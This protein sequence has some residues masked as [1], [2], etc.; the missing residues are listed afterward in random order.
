MGDGSEEGAGLVHRSYRN[1]PVGVDPSI[2]LTPPPCPYTAD[3]ARAMIEAAIVSGDGSEVAAAGNA[4]TFHDVEMT[5]GHIEPPYTDPVDLGVHRFLM[6]LLAHRILGGGE[7]AI[8]GFRWNG[9]HVLGKE[10]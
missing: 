6:S 9:R 4:I 3:Q 8:A 10:A 2:P 5:L 1:R 7:V